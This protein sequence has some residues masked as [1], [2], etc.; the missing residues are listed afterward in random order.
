M[1]RSMKLPTENDLL[2][3]YRITKRNYVER[4]IEDDKD[5]NSKNDEGYTLLMMAVFNDKKI[6][7]ISCGKRCRS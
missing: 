6:T 5:I 1:A 2:H 3:S 7:Q 4:A